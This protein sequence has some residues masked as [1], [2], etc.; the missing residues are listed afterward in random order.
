M[1]ECAGQRFQGNAWRNH[2]QHDVAQRHRARAKPLRR[3][4]MHGY[5]HQADLL[6]VGAQ[7][8]GKYAGKHLTSDLCQ[9][10]RI[11]GLRVVCG[12]ARSTDDQDAVRA[13]MKRRRGRCHLA[14]STVAEELVAD[15]GRREYE[16][17]RARCEQ[18]WDPD[19]G[20][21]PD[22]LRSFPQ[23]KRRPAHAKAHRHAGAIAR[24][25]NGQR[26]EHAGVDAVFDRRKVNSP[27]K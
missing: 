3:Y 13:K 6:Q 21:H 20:P 22:A 9:R 27:R 24:C 18:V 15:L 16:W 1:S 25:G 2:Q 19:C 17:N 5:I 12:A 4:L 14:H 23:R 7:R 8:V 11:R 26:I 10:W